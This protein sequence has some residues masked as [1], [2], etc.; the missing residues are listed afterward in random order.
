[1]IRSLCTLACTSLL[2]GS[3]LA[4]EYRPW[5]S[6]DDETVLSVSV[7]QHAQVREAYA[8][9]A[10]GSKLNAE[11][12]VQRIEDYL[13]QQQPD[14]YQQLTAGMTMFGFEFKDIPGLVSGAFGGALKLRSS[15]GSEDAPDYTGIIW[16]TPGADLNQRLLR[17]L[18]MGL[19]LQDGPEERQV[20]RWD[21]QVGDHTVIELRGPAVET[22]YVYD[23][24]GNMQVE[25]RPASGDPSF[26]V[27]MDGDRLLLSIQPRRDD[28]SEDQQRL[29]SFVH[30]SGD[31]QVRAFGQRVVESASLSAQLRLEGPA[32]LEVYGDIERLL[33]L[34]PEDDEGPRFGPSPQDLIQAFGLNSLRMAGLRNT[35]M[36]NRMLTNL[37][38]EAAAPRQG[39]LGIVD[40]EPVSRQ[41]PGWMQD[42]VMDGQVLRLDL[43]K[44][45]EVIRATLVAIEP[46]AEQQFNE[47]NQG[48]SMFLG[49]DIPT[50]LG[51]FGDV[52]E[53]VTFPKTAEEIAAAEETMDP[54]D[55]TSMDNPFDVR[56]AWVMNARNPDLVAHVISTAAPMMGMQMV[57]EQGY[58]GFRLEE[59]M[60]GL[61]AG[62]FH[63]ND[64]VI[65]T[66]GEGVAERALNLQRNPPQASEQLANN[67]Q[68][69]AL[70]AELPQHPIVS[71]SYQNTAQSVRESMGL[72]NT[73]FTAAAGEVIAEL[74]MHHDE[75]GVE[76]FT[77]STLPDREDFANAF[78]ITVQ[79]LY[80]NSQGIG[81]NLIMELPPKE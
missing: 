72:W 29:M 3:L 49:S 70:Q 61:S 13:R 64:Q 79:Q 19:Q 66:M 51:A 47:V 16:F 63:G 9:S 15:A 28:S 41:L 76:A 20:T 56:L 57:E 31:Q 36:H 4:E 62:L 10:L 39:I 24:E 32:Q 81:G 34:I 30:A 14:I 68:F 44:V 27:V 77:S 23:D 43:A 11:I 42:S 67:D 45:Y 35:F 74:G 50:I 48:A 8:A 58:T 78:G 75:E 25:D 55:P 60:I 2:A 22:A 53:V 37:F 73:L 80:V 33:S 40:Q 38:I 69:L 12:M 17:A 65:I 5:Q 54:N 21:H 1:M 26:L 46:M 7:S 6:L 52:H 18:E 59:P 71:F